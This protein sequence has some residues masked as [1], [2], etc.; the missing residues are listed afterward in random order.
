MFGMPILKAKGK[1]FAG[2]YGDAMTFKLPEPSYGHAMTLKG[3]A[4]FDP[5]GM[6]RPMMGRP[7]KEW[8]IVPVVHAKSWAELA[9]AA[10]TYVS[11]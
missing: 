11:G 4:Q 3:A 1:A 5:S 2:L 8:V 9:E 6:G 10:R 7:M